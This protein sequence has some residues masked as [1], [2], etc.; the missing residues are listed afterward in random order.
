M[1]QSMVSQSRIVT[2]QQQQQQNNCN[3][4]SRGRQQK[5]NSRKA[6]VGA[7]SESLQALPS[8]NWL[9]PSL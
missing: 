3:I 9:H 4:C 5:A 7:P 2:E 6:Q 8:K 1:L